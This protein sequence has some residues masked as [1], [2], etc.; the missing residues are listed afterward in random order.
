MKLI[1]SA[2][3]TTFHHIPDD[4][5]SFNDIEA[6]EILVRGAMCLPFRSDSAKTSVTVRD[7][8]GHAW[9][10]PFLGASRHRGHASVFRPNRGKTTTTTT[11]ASGQLLGPA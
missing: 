9:R 1:K 7:S 10:L 6:Y 2:K 8:N 4:D 11:V 3:K 5:Y